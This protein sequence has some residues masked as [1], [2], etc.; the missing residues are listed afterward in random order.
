[1]NLSPSE[2]LIASRIVRWI[3]VRSPVTS[4]KPQPFLTVTVSTHP[5]FRFVAAKIE[6]RLCVTVVGAYFRGLMRTSVSE[7]MSAYVDDAALRIG[8]TAV[9]TYRTIVDGHVIPTLGIVARTASLART[10]SVG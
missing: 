8:A 7:A 1:M 9:A 3:C 5:R 4:A 10:L 2:A 6:T